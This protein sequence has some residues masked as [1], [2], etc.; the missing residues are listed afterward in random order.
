MSV[1]FEAGGQPISEASGSITQPI[2][3]GCPDFGQN[4][5]F[6]YRAPEGMPLFDAYG[7][8]MTS[9]MIGVAVRHGTELAA[10]IV[11]RGNEAAP[12]Q[13]IVDTPCRYTSVVTEMIYHNRDDCK[14]RRC[15]SR[16]PLRDND[17]YWRSDG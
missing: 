15:A 16:E 5:F 7:I 2:C 1:Q 6:E 17:N 3:P 11:R 13:E 12:G 10:E 8:K 4:S 9:F 14:R